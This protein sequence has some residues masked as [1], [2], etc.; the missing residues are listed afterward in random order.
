MTIEPKEKVKYLG[1][2]FETKGTLGKHLEL[3][4]KRGGE[5]L[6]TSGTVKSQWKLQK[7]LCSMT[8]SVVRYG[9]P[10]WSEG[11]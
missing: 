2:T 10:N 7:I 1:I 4:T 9:T 5:K 6:A 3:V 8:N 11:L